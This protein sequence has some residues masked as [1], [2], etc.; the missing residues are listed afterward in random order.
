ADGDA[1]LFQPLYDELMWHDTYQLL[2]D[3]RSYL[4]AQAQVEQ[5]WREPTRWTR[6]SILNVARSGKFSSDRAVV[7]YCNS[8]WKTTPVPV[9]M[10][11]AESERA[12]ILMP[13][14]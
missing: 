5:V 3:Y 4:D 12:E 13:V 14:R 10:E 2:A 11:L 6:M 8:I 9:G 7:E 1:A